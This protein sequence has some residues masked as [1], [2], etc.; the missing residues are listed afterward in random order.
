VPQFTPF[1]RITQCRYGQ[2]IYNANDVYIGKSL[3]L[4][5]EYG[6]GEVH[7][8]RQILRPGDFAVDAGANIGA[9]TLFFAEAVGPSGVVLAFEPQRVVFQTLCGNM[10]IN[11]IT[12]AHCLNAA[13][14]SAPGQILVPPL[15][16]ARENNFGGLGLGQFQRGERVQVA[17]LD[18]L[19]LPRCKLMK[20]DVEGMEE[21][22]LKG[23]ESTI[24]RCRP[25]LYVENDREERSHALI[26]YIDSLGYRMFWHQPPLYNPD[27]Y[28]KNPQNVFGAIVSANMLCLHKSIEAMPGGFTPVE[29]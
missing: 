28:R 12:N 16:Y 11:S 8:F 15:D 20:V 19:G 21:E 29:I 10:A 3:E 7:L 1:N 27:N 23:G 6:E 14:G 17:T 2:M 24:T 25:V 18:S 26:R 13:L 5:G 9:H 22:V 4:Y